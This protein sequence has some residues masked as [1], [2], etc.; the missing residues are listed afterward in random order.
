MKKKDEQLPM[1]KSCYA[2]MGG[3]F[4]LRLTERLEELGWIIKDTETKHFLI[5]AKGEKEFKKLGVDTSD[6]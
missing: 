3:K 6:L 4:G 2:H 1:I 5:T